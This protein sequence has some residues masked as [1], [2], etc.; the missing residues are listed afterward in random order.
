M[1]NQILIL[2][3]FFNYITPALQNL[4]YEMHRKCVLTLQNVFMKGW[5]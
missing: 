1:L 2:Q 3:V 5:L 4:P